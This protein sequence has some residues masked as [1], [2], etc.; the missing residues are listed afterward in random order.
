VVSVI[1]D[2]KYG[3]R[4]EMKNNTKTV[5]V[6]GSNKGIGKSIVE[7]LY[8]NKFNIYACARKKSDEHTL[9]INNLKNKNN[10]ESFI[11]EIYFDFEN[12]ED[13]KKS[14]EKI[15]LS[16]DKI[17]G[18]INN[19]GTIHTAPFQMT[20]IKTFEKVFDV[21]FFSQLYFTQ[22]ILKNMMKQKEG[23][24]VNMSSTAAFDGVEGRSAYSSSKAALVSVTKVMAKELAKFNIR[25][26]AIAPGLTNTDML[27][28]N[29]SQENITKTLEKTFLKRVAEPI[30]IAK[31]ALFLISD[32]SSYITGQTLRID[33]GMQ[34]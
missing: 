23:S 16:E 8:N 18:L 31:V 27:K 11:K 7:L 9:F 21:N 19:A 33:G 24:V 34:L 1:S 10:S 6:T 28:K 5:V 20:A 29:H 26:N 14:A 30:E 32:S 3:T 12:R 4:I 25:V 15:I 13:V 22:Y 17:Y 2:K